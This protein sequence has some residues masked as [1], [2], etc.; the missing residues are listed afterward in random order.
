MNFL[1]HFSNGF[2]KGDMFQI[3]NIKFR[4]ISYA[5]K[6]K[7]TIEINYDL[8]Q[9]K[10][11]L[12]LLKFNVSPKYLKKQESNKTSLDKLTKRLENKKKEDKMN[13]LSL[14]KYA[15]WDN[16]CNTKLKDI[17]KTIY[18][19]RNVE[20]IIEEY[21]IPRTKRKIEFFFEFLERL[22]KKEE[23]S[24]INA[25]MNEGLDFIEDH[26]RK[27]LEKDNKEKKSSFCFD[28]LN[29]SFDQ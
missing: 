17:Y 26:E 7:N 4:K 2:I 12:D 8:L 18:L 19:A 5:E 3:H 21:Q 22:R 10:T 11:F 28:D 25:L 9:N 1:F 6:S 27:M 13:N 23:K 15:K 14:D 29:F 20:K 24:Y 16:Y